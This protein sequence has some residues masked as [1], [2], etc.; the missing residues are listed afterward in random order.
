MHTFEVRTLIDITEN[1]ILKSAFPF[2]TKSNEIVHDKNSL[3]IARNQQSN[4]TTLIQV[5]QIRA[6]IIWENSP[7][8]NEGITANT[9]FGTTYNGKHTHWTFKFQTEQPDVYA[10]DPS[11]TG[12]LEEDMDLVPIIN[13]C[14]ETATFPSATFITLDDKTRNTYISAIEEVDT[15]LPAEYI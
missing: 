8:R 9:K 14:K 15:G 6:N 4:F 5:L 12:Q 2:K 7:I 1:G 11:P 3:F 10:L 13:F